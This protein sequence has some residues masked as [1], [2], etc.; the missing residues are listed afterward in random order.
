MARRESSTY[1]KRDT[2]KPWSSKRIEVDNRS[3][4]VTLTSIRQF[5][6]VGYKNKQ[7]TIEKNSKR[8][9]KIRAKN[10]GECKSDE[11]TRL[12]IHEN[13]KKG[14]NVNNRYGLIFLFV[15]TITQILSF[16]FSFSM[17]L[18]FC[19]LENLLQDQGVMINC[20]ICSIARLTSIH[21]VGTREIILDV[22]SEKKRTITSVD[23]RI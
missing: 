23:N 11:S 12:I 17:S 15:L 22:P 5:E 18:Y 21:R 1:L 2:R 14:E 7:T 9:M 13:S 10:A 8:W 20:I 4:M 6:M 16:F 3:S 19:H